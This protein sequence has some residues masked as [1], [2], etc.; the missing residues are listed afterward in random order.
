MIVSNKKGSHQT[1][2]MA[3]PL[4][5]EAGMTAAVRNRH[6]NTVLHRYRCNLPKKMIAPRSTVVD[7]GHGQMG[8]PS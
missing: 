2:E 5:V 7:D 3:D 6:L 1:N 4:P 8:T